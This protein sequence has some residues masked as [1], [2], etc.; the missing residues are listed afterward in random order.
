MTAKKKTS[1][2]KGREQQGDG[3]TAA[4]RRLNKRLQSFGFEVYTA[5]L[6]FF[7]INADNPAALKAYIKA[8]KP[9]DEETEKLAAR[10]VALMSNKRTP[11]GQRAVVSDIINELATGVQV[12]PDHPAL[13]RAFWIE[14]SKLQGS[15]KPE[16]E[17]A[18]VFALI[19][20]GE[21]FADYEEGE[22]NLKVWKK[23]RAASVETKG[24]AS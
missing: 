21:K 24:G 3:M 19:D 16:R 1:T 9:A 5:A 20:A 13:A 11:N 2:I 10:L 7:T 4:E 14:A 12:W 18:E 17:L 8:L 15:I 22:D 23:R 6:A